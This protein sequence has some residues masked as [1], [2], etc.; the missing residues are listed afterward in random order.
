[1]NNK[2][3]II[4][5]AILIYFKFRTSQTNTPI[6]KG[7]INGV[8]TTLTKEEAKAKQEADRLRG[9]IDV[10]GDLNFTYVPIA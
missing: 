8:P 6:Y 3:L 1:M 7:F 9:K 5:A 2:V 4:I 10:F